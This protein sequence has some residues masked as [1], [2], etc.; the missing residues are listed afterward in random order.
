MATSWRRRDFVYRQQLSDY[1]KKSLFSTI[2]NLIDNFVS[3]GSGWKVDHMMSLSISFA[4]YRPLQGSSYI[5][6]P[7][8]LLRKQAVL[9]I[10]IFDDNYC[11]IYAILANIHPVGRNSRPELLQNTQSLWQNLTMKD[12]SFYWR[13]LIFLSWRRWILIFPSMY[14]FVTIAI[15]STL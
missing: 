4:T 11:I 12:Y 9:N 8:E 14:Y 13:S 10:Q 1:D 5:P 7:N 3:V 6:T 2:M 15:H